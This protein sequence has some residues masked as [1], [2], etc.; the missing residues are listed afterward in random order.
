MRARC[1]F[2]AYVQNSIRSRRHLSYLIY[3]KKKR[4][5]NASRAYNDLVV[6]SRSWSTYTKEWQLLTDGIIFT[7]AVQGLRAYN[8]PYIF[9]TRWPRLTQSRR[10][11][12]SSNP[13]IKFASRR[14]FGTRRHRISR[15]WIN[16]KLCELRVDEN[17]NC[18]CTLEIMFTR[19]SNGMYHRCDTRQTRYSSFFQL[20][21]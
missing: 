17:V 7:L 10:A 8:G 13:W 14:S 18:A 15:S 4:G 12:V 3:K 6:V 16:C 9:A 21:N 2:L 11:R 20:H 5:K 1:F 19:N